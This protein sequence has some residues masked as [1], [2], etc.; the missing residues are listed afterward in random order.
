MNRKQ[1]DLSV[2]SANEYE[3]LVAEI[4]FPDNFGLIISQEKEEGVFDISVHS[5]RKNSECEFAYC[6]NIDLAKVPLSVLLEAIQDAV[7][8]LKRLARKPGR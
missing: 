7:S 6:K 4:A 3:D 1:Y 2:G 5:F 8:E